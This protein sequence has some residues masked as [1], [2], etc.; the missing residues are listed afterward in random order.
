MRAVALRRPPQGG[1]R[2]VTEA[3]AVVSG[4]GDAPTWPEPVGVGGGGRPRRA[5]QGERVES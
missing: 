2:A 4:R 3:G 5:G 1:G